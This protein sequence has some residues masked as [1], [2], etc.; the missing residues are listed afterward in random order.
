MPLPTFKNPSLLQ[1]ALTHR[2]YVNEHDDEPEDNE[3]LEFLG[4]AVVDLIAGAMLYHRYPEMLEGRLTRLR[5]ALVRTEQLAAFAV[6]VGIRDRLRLGRGEDDTGGRDRDSLLCG[7]FEAVVGAYYL[8]AG[9]EAARD[10]V[11][12][13]LRLAVDHILDAESD[14]DPKS[15]LQEW[16]QAELG[17]TPAYTTVGVSGPD[18]SRQFTVE[19]RINGEVY[20]LG[21][22]RSKQ[23]AAQD[24][25]Q[26]ALQRLGLA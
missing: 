26:D 20:G 7:A 5:A 10:F 15:Q 17:H 12:P 13:L 4:D 1:R 14:E 3:R 25:A 2:S 19:A 16:S 8:D 22:G 6:Q 11:E 23:A 21:T 18:H 9:Y 24:A